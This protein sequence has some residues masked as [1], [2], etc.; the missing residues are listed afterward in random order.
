MN[1]KKSLKVVGIVAVAVF[2][3][4]GCS[5]DDDT[6]GGGGYTGS[7]GSVTHGGK[8]YKTVK[9]G[10]QTWFAENLDYAF[11]GS[12]CY[13]NSSSNC[14]M[15]GRLY[16]W[17]DANSACPSGWHLPSDAEWTQLT[18]FVGGAAT[19]GKKLKSTSGWNDN[20]NGT[21]QY[22]FSALPG[23][24]GNSLVGFFYDA[25]DHGYWWSATEDGV[26][27]AWYRHMSYGSEYVDRYSDEKTF[28]NS[29]RCVKN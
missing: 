9:I 8:T 20:G 3:C 7:Y 26:Q 21:N 17:G 14:T 6:G 12:V 2:V 19:V 15:Y 24:D 4:I 18:D 13:K 16:T 22:G 29:V 1:Y 28:L 5:E 25:G 27:Y 23:G 11:G 10:S